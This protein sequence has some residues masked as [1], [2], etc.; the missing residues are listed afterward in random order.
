MHTI[1]NQRL[2]NVEEVSWLN[3]GLN[4]DVGHEA[5]LTLYNLVYKIDLEHKI[6]TEF[7][8]IFVVTDHILFLSL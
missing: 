3:P 5:V 6:I 8:S 7:T 4:I 2:I 1:L